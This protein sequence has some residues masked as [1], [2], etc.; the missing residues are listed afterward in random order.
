M[1]GLHTDDAQEHFARDET[2]LSKYS[3]R[4]QIRSSIMDS[5]FDTDTEIAEAL[6]LKDRTRLATCAKTEGWMDRS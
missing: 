1:Y 6:G 3:S 4:L 5:K 2:E